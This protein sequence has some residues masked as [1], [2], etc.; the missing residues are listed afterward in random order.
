MSKAS[1]LHHQRLLREQSARTLF[2]QRDTSEA[3]SRL[4]DPDTSREAAQGLGDLSKNQRAL[5]SFW[6]EFRS[7]VMADLDLVR[8]YQSDHRAVSQSPSGIRS[9]RAELVTLGLVEA[10]GTT[11]IFGR[12]HT[13]WKLTAKGKAL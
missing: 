12:K 13:L 6:R 5:L 10:C 1:A 8:H 4:T 11:P 9:R 7:G 2:D 3:H